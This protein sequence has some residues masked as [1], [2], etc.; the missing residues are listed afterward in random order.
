LLENTR[1]I[2]F[3]ALPHRVIEVEAVETHSATTRKRDPLAILA[4]VCIGLSV[5]LSQ[6][7]ISYTTSLLALA[8][9]AAVLHPN[10]ALWIREAAGRLRSPLGIAIG[11]VFIAWMPSLFVSVD[12]AKSVQVWFRSAAYLCLGSVLWAFL[13]NNPRSLRLAQKAL[14]A[15]AAI[16][17]LLVAVNFLGGTE[18]I[19]ALRFKEFTEGYPPKVM[20][21]YAAPAAC[22]I[23]IL[24][25]IGYRL[26]RAVLFCSLAS[27]A[28]L[29]V[30][31]YLTG[32]GAAVMGLLLGAY[33]VAITWLGRRHVS[34][35]IVGMAVLVAAI[36]AWYVWF[37]S[38][39]IPNHADFEGYP[40]SPYTVD[41]HRQI[42]WL[43]VMSRIP[44]AMWFGYGIDAINKIAGAGEIIEVLKAEYLPSHPHSWALEILAETGVV[45]YSAFIGALGI[46]FY[47]TCRKAISGSP[48]AL[49]AVGLLGVYF[50]SGLFSFSVW[51]SWWQLVLIILWAMTAAMPQETD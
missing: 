12:P 36:V 46:A 6:I 4:A 20:K 18:Y 50:G 37:A 29:I 2:R 43:F 10:R 11:I 44:D 21:L 41:R 9:V 22:L 7:G 30:F 26:G 34:I 32:S 25:C 23:P 15:A 3:S 48:A 17:V 28:G 5:P 35:S 13:W 16:S 40:I 31:I 42:I 19:R 47:G 14:I 51:A 33:C 49:A 39:T 24:I 1:G 38:Q 45:G 27:S 8:S